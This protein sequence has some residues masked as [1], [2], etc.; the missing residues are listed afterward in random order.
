MAET[1]EQSDRITA[2]LE[3]VREYSVT[4][5]AEDTCG[6]CEMMLLVKPFFFFI[7]GHKFHSDCLEKQVVPMLSKEQLRRL[8]TLRQ[9]LEAEV[10][11]PAQAQSLILSNEQAKELQRK[12]ATLKTE[13]EDILAA[14][15][16]FCGLLIDTIDQPFVDDWEQVNVEWE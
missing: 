13:I 6:V 15:C 7:C 1:Q 16:L 10:Q 9:Q 2:E 14:D 11:P 5:T 8:T 3:E 4:M 12:R